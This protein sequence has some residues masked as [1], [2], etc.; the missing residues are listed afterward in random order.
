ML[1]VTSLHPLGKTW[2]GTRRAFQIPDS[3]TQASPANHAKLR[4]DKHLF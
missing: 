2:Q 3:R 4:S 1:E